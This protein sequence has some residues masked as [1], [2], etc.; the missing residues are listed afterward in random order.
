VSGFNF[1]FEGPE[2]HP[3][4][5][6]CFYRSSSL[7]WGTWKDRWQ[8]ADWKMSDYH[9]FCA[10]KLQQQ[11]FNR[12][13]DDLS[14]M[15][16]L[17]MHGKIDSW[18]IR[19][20]YTHFRQDA[21]ALLSLLPRVFHIGSDSSA[22]YSR[23]KSFKQ[24]PLTTERKSEFRFP[25]T[26]GLEEPFVLELQRSLRPSLARKIV[27]YLLHGRMSLATNRFYPSKFLPA[28]TEHSATPEASRRSFSD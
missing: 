8:R 12:G 13:G 2:Y 14:G 5:A 7:G 26:A 25:D 4:D 22:T 15:L 17:Q 28:E 21:F 9:T 27:R 16:A 6:F 3:Y 1:G 23:R 18:A 24:L 20:A 19:W 10:D 11:Q